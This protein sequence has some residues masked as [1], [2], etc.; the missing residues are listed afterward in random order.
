MSPSSSEAHE[1]HIVAPATRSSSSRDRRKRSGLGRGLGALIPELTQL[2]TDAIVSLIPVTSIAP[3]PYQPRSELD[4]ADFE[5]LVASV[6][7]HGV[8]Q[9]VIVSETETA[10]QYVLI[11]G[12]R[13]WRAAMRAGLAGIPALVK[14]ATPQEMLELALVENVVRSDLSPLEEAIAYRQLIDDFGLTQLDVA[15]RVGRSRVSVTNT[16]RLLFAPEAVKLALQEGRISE[17]HA[18]ALLSLATAADQVTMLESILNKDMTVRQAEAAVRSWLN[19]SEKT[20]TDSSISVKAGTTDRAI[21]DRMQR[22][23]A[24][25]V[26]LR[27]SAAGRGVIS[28]RFDSDEQLEEIVARIGGEPLF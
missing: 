24:T 20:T 18:R 22:S 12:E 11:A 13:R 14:D 19:R 8:L 7:L 9:P 1:D 21:V 5:D 23:L 17:G 15:R 16:L 10:D 6:Q 25:Q 4:D 2:Q 3:N 27:K 28:I 26:T